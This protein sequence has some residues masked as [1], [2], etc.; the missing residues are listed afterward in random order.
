MTE[1]DTVTGRET[2][3]VEIDDETITGVD[4]GMRTIDVIAEITMMTDI[5]IGTETG[6]EIMIGAKNGREIVV[7]MVDE[8]TGLFLHGRPL[9]IAV[10][11][12][13]DL[14]MFLP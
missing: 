14:P 12:P 9:M 6:T 4:I 10:G 7:E 11:R 13:V 3:M 2:E 1:I 5:E 8:P